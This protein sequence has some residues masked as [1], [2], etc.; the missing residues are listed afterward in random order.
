MDFASKI[1]VS[2][3]SDVMVLQISR[4]LPS[5]VFSTFVS[6]LHFSN[7]LATKSTSLLCDGTLVFEPGMAL[8]FL[9]KEPILLDFLLIALEL[10]A[11]LIF[12][13]L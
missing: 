7:D 8:K 11:D 2:I 5:G 12:P 4:S 13:N 9:K 10:F 1:M 3:D 6:M